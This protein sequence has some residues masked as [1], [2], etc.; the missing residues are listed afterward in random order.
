MR[1][2]Y[3]QAEQPFLSY[4]I[5][6]L[7]T[8]SCYWT[9][10]VSQIPTGIQDCTHCKSKGLISESVSPTMRC[11]GNDVYETFLVTK[12]NTTE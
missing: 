2:A 12:S 9:P 4:L 6:G 10:P 5:D 3:R 8:S 7:L 11:D 1:T